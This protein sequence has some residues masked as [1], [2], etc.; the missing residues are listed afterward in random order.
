MYALWLRQSGES[1]TE[2]GFQHL[3]AF[4]LLI[5]TPN[6]TPDQT[7]RLNNRVASIMSR[8]EECRYGFFNL[9]NYVKTQ[10][11]VA[12]AMLKDFEIHNMLECFSTYGCLSYYLP[13]V[14]SDLKGW[15]LSFI[16]F[17]FHDN[18]F[19][20]VQFCVEVGEIKPYSG[21]ILVNNI[22]NINSA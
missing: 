21:Y 16:S 20:F 19:M 2:S 7:Q 5:L 6:R 15:L 17:F 10:Q 22:E 1:E 4:V 9:C 8:S 11:R 18:K 14:L 3:I 13:E 12:V